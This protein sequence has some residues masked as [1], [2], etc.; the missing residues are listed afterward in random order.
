MS[1]DYGSFDTALKAAAGEDSALI[2]ELRATFV[3]SAKRQLSLLTR[4]RCDANWQYTSW[5]LKGLAA[6]FGAM[7]LMLLADE[8]VEGAP[9]DP[10]V[11]RKIGR[12]IQE[13]ETYE[14]TA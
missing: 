5:R 10:V 3:E 12:A 6:S 1:M 4:S 2:A 13:I 11:L 14:F 9:G 7:K 8:A